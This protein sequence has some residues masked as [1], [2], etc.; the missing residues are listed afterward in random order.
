MWPGHNYSPCIPVPWGNEKIGT[1]EFREE[2]TVRNII[3]LYRMTTGTEEVNQ[4]LLFILILI[5]QEQWGWHSMK[6]VLNFPSFNQRKYLFNKSLWNSLPPYITETKSLVG[7]KR[8]LAIYMDGKSSL[9]YNKCILKNQELWKGTLML[10]C[11][12]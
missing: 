5:T 7:F 12:I 10:W 3:K 6:L 11:I 9:R 2:M 8:G 4:E 1:V